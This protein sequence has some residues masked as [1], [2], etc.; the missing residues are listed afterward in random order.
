MRIIKAFVL[1]GN[2]LGWL[3]ADIYLWT[4]SW[5]CGLGGIIGL[6]GFF[7]GYSVSKGMTVA[8]RD[9]WRL[10]NYEVFK[11]K[12]VYANSI[13]GSVTATASIVLCVIKTIIES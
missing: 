5:C 10:P 3:I 4:L 11:K 2:I 7:W 13:M 9:Y 6:A 12:L 1:L 8:P